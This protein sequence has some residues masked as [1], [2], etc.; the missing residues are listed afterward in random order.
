MH[1]RRDE[2]RRRVNWPSLSTGSVYEPERAILRE[3]HNLHGSAA[4][5]ATH[6][7]SNRGLHTLPSSD[8]IRSRSTRLIRSRSSDGTQYSCSYRAGNSASVLIRQK[9]PKLEE[10]PRQDPFLL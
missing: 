9:Q 2:T 5:A 8:S 3:A 7:G 10:W 4:P 1:A 6:F